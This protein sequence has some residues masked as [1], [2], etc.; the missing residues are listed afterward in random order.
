MPSQALEKVPPLE[1]VSHLPVR[2]SASLE[3][4]C[5]YAPFHRRAEE[6]RT[7]R[8]QLLI[9]WFNP[10]EGRK[11]LAVVSPGSGEG[12]SYVAANLAV[13]FAQLGEPVLLIDADMRTPRQH[14]IFGIAE[15]G[16]LSAILS[17]RADHTAVAPV[18][19]IAGLSLLPAGA[20]PPNPQELLSRPAFT[21]LLKEM[22]AR[23]HLILIDTPAAQLY[24]DVQNVAYRA[25]DALMLARRDHTRLAETIKATRELSDTG[26]RVV[27][28]V[29]NTF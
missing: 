6:L 17:G 7:L 15:R 5:A 24:A 13:V 28:A 29:M 14:A 26:A 8:T 22:Q 11:T 27:G 19:G 9:H 25:G 21:A 3:L 12:R 4:V 1:V 18:P 10:D 16:G 20:L 23:F 2:T